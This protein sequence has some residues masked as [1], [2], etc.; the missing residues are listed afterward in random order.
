MPL[1]GIGS[2]EETSATDR[3]QVVK[4]LGELMYAV[5]KVAKLLNLQA[6]GYRLV[7]NHGK[8]G[9]QTVNWLHV[10]LLGGRSLQWPPG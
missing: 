5:P 2:V 1:S 3:D 10:H 6:N 9:C 8:D 4:Q 7:I